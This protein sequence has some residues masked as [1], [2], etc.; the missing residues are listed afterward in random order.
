MAERQSCKLKVLGSIPSGGLFVNLFKIEAQGIFE[1][2][3]GNLRRQFAR[4]VKGVDLRS[5]GGNSAWV[6]TPQLTCFV[7]GANG[8]SRFGNHIAKESSGYHDSLAERSKAVAQGAIPKG[9]GFE[10]HSCHFSAIAAQCA[11]QVLSCFSINAWLR[12]VFML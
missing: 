3:C 1:T 4:V 9:R 7:N 5:T 8:R 11:H 10:P 12:E 2:E 6:R